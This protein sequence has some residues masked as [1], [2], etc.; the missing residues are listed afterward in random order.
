MK[1]SAVGHQGHPTLCAWEKKMEMIRRHQHGSLVPSP[2]RRLERAS[3]NTYT[4]PSA[5]GKETQAA[6]YLSRAL[7]L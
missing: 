6:K 2:C 5:R 4:E 3:D 7:D 1:S